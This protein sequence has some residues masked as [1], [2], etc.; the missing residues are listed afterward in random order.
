VEA[1]PA[2]D[3]QYG[4]VWD[5]MNEIQNE[6]LVVAPRINIYNIDFLG[7]PYTSLAG[8]VVRYV[9]ES[10]RPEAERLEGYS[11][12]ELAERAQALQS[13]SQV[14]EELAARM[15]AVRL[16]LAQRWLPQDDPFLREAIRPG[17]TAEQAATRLVRDSR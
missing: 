12:A 1:D 7:D 5:R 6:K 15:L 16:R 13:P 10:A 17:E 9:R 8:G 4:D 3:S 14:N 2:L 11:D